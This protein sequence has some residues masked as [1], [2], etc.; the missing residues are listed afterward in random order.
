MVQLLWLV[1]VVALRTTVLL[2]LAFS[3]AILLR[4]SSARARRTVWAAALIGCVAMPLVTYFGPTLPVPVLRKR[5]Y[6]DVPRILRGPTPATT[7]LVEAE[8]ARTILPDLPPRPPARMPTPPKLGVVPERP[9]ETATARSPIWL[10]LLTAT[11]LLGVLVVGIR[12]TGARLAAARLARRADVVDRALWPGADGASIRTTDAIDL[13][14]TVGSLWPTILVPRSGSGWAPEHRAMVIAHEVAHV[15]RR[16]P[17]V[18]LVADLACTLHWFHPL[19]WLAARRL[20]IERE[21][22]A[23]DDVLLGGTLPSA[24]ADLLVELASVPTALP[25]LGAVVPILSQGGLKA[26]LLGVLDPGR[27]RSLGRPVHVAL[28]VVGFVVFV[29]VALAVPISRSEEALSLLGFGRVVGRVF[30][31]AKH[32]VSDAEVFFLLDSGPGLPRSAVVRSD[33]NGWFRYPAGASAQGSFDVYARKGHFVARKPILLLNKYGTQLPIELDMRPGY[34]LHG[35]VRGE[36]GAP[37]AGAKVRFL[38]FESWAPGPGYDVVATSDETGRF[39][40]DGLSYGRYWLV[41]EAPW[42]VA[43]TTFANVTDHDVDGVDVVVNRDWAVTGRLRDETGAPVSGARVGD[44]V[45]SSLGGPPWLNPTRYVHWDESRE[46]G[47]FRLLPRGRMLKVWAHDRA[48]EV[49]VGTFPDGGEA[50]VH[51]RRRGDRLMEIPESLVPEKTRPLDQDGHEARIKE[52]PTAAQE[53]AWAI[54]GAL[55]SMPAPASNRDLA[56][57]LDSY[58]GTHTRIVSLKLQVDPAPSSASLA[59]TERGTPPVTDTLPSERSSGWSI[60]WTSAERGAP[61]DKIAI[62]VDLP[63]R[64]R[65]ILRMEWTRSGL[66]ETLSPR[67][68]PVLAVLKRA[69]YVSGVVRWDDGSPAAGMPVSETHLWM[70]GSISPATTDCNG[71][72]QLGPLEPGSN[73]EVYVAGRSPPRSALGRVRVALAPGEHRDGLMITIPGA[74][75]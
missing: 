35:G 57:K 17:L 22:A 66:D 8:S 56:M 2:L 28:A 47:S 5:T 39:G 9:R 52:A 64:S 49:I 10:P 23:D 59:I 20:R 33:R 41:V 31:E 26:R 62:P 55:K 7:P 63:D 45:W 37:V 38:R 3:I 11:W 44:T 42:G 15:R 69:A 1:G 21:L 73:V 61:E 30:D 12:K 14:I 60:G 36:A 16:D 24:Y 74:P 6:D 50:L 72:F 43:T 32:P 70:G 18:Q 67:R 29:P 19:V 25:R 34:A 58:Y 4:R 65:A 27:A 75:Q 46:D 13:P 48:G 53:L 71:Q 51:S 68:V 54:A 40:I